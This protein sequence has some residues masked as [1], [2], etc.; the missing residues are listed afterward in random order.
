M[1]TID[2]IQEK[3]IIR[4]DFHSARL[5][6]MMTCALVGLSL[7][8][9]VEAVPEFKHFMLDGY[10]VG[11]EAAPA[12]VDIDGDGDLDAFIGEVTGA[13]QFF[14]ND[15]TNLA[16]SFAADVTGNP[17]AGIT[18]LSRAVPTF[19]DIDGDGDADAF[20][21]DAFGTTYYFRNDGT[22]L[23][24]AFVAVVGAANP[25]NGIFQS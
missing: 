10:N 21:G 22:S 19:A 20:V 24:P 8:A 2:R 23:A 15:G 18:V 3:K 11:A 7:P 9:T 16:P 12:F 5:V 4:K 1:N 14:R 17:L 6:L 25:L 13:V